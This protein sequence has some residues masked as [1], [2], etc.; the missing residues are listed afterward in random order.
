MRS[1]HLY[2]G[3]ESITLFPL[4]SGGSKG[5]TISVETPEKVEPIKQEVL[6]GSG[7]G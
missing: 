6:Y 4:K 1:Q 5:S 7:N 2:A 3:Q